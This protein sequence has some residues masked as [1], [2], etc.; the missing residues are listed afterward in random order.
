MKTVSIGGSSFSPDESK[1]LVSSNETGVFNVYELDLAT[2]ERTPVTEGDDTTFA[3]AYMPNGGRILFTRD[4]AGNEINHL[5]LR[6][7]DG[8]VR[9]L[10]AGEE[11][12]EQFA[13]FSND[14]ESFY[15]L[16]NGRDERFFDL[17]K[18]NVATLDHEMV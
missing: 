4:Q 3:V 17:Y 7:T 8:T 18:W 10:T 1:L 16:N 9:D 2:T 12:K 13:G 11:T 6:E 14:L 5:Y 15:T